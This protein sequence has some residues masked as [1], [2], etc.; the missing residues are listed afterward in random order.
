MTIADLAA[1]SVAD[2]IN[3]AVQAAIGVI[4]CPPRAAGPLEFMPNRALAGGARWA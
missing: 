3:V 1:T 2:K 4:P